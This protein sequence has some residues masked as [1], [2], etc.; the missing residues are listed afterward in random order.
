MEMSAPG[1]AEPSATVQLTD[2]HREFCDGSSHVAPVGFEKGEEF[3]G[4]HGE[5]WNHGVPSQC[6]C[7]HLPYGMC[8]DWFG[9]EYAGEDLRAASPGRGETA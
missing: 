2:W 1:G 4:S 9:H 3:D 8:P 5:A 7:G 6:M